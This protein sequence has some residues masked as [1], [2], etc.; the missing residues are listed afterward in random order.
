MKAALV[1]PRAFPQLH[2]TV[3]HPYQSCTSPRSRLRGDFLMRTR[4]MRPLSICKREC[5]LPVLTILH[6]A[7]ELS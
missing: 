1:D 7:A 5:A 6:R 4:E 3:P 2:S